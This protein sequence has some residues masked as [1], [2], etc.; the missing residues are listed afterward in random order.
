MNI[1][2]VILG[3]NV[4]M[5]AC[6]CANV[7]IVSIFYNNIIIILPMVSNKDFVLLLGGHGLGNNK[8]R[9]IVQ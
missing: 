9:S 4:V 6:K 3:V 8:T 1:H 2:H 5:Y 7:V